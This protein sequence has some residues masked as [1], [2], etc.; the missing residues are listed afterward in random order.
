MPELPE[1]ETIVR[2]LR[3]RLLGATIAAV[4]TSGKGLRLARAVDRAALARDSVAARV[5]TVRRKGK[6]IL[7]DL[8]AS[9]RRVS[10]ACLC[11]PVRVDCFDGQIA[12]RRT[13]SISGACAGRA[14]AHRQARG[15]G[16]L[17]ATQGG[18]VAALRN[19]RAG[20]EGTGRSRRESLPLWF[21]CSR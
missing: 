13:R 3:P 8:D 15:Q 11:L 5:A 9:N 6:Y 4:W 12:S 19:S 18:C 2:T 21:V 14:I 10:Y 1:V 17:G 16:T 7:I 20:Q